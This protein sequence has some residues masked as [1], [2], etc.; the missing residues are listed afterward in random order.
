MNA[1]G[2]EW[3][4]LERKQSFGAEVIDTVGTFCS[5][6]GGVIEVSQ[7]GLLKPIG[8]GRARSYVVP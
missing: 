3:E 6:Y 4:R 5:T 2:R 1:D 8:E 7:A